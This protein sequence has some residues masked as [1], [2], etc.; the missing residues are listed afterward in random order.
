MSERR[1][2]EEIKSVY[3]VA[4]DIIYNQWEHP[5]KQYKTGF[6]QLDDK[7]GGGFNAGTLSVLGANPSVGKTTLALQMACN[8]AK[9]G[10]SVLFFSLEMSEV[11]I[12]AKIISRETRENEKEREKWLTTNEILTCNKYTERDVFKQDI[13]LKQILGEWLQNIY[14]ITFKEQASVE[15]LQGKIKSFIEQKK[16]LWSVDWEEPQF[17]VTSK[18][19]YSLNP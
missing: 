18:E 6:K 2:E 9:A 7:L 19:G 8:M 17:T 11:E 3:E 13:T 16:L 15:D 10:E 5:I 14:I 1:E 12:V 4:K